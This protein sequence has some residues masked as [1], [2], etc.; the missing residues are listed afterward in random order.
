MNAQQ[1]AIS[2]YFSL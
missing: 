2:L 1:D